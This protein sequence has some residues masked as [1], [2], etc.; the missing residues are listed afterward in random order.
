MLEVLD[1]APGN[2]TVWGEGMLVSARDATTIN[3]FMAHSTYLEDGSRSTGGHPSSAVIPALLALGEARSVSGDKVILGL[4]L[5]YEIFI[6]VGK[7]L[8]PSTVTRGFQPTA[9]LAS[10]G[11]AGGCA[12]LLDLKSDACAQALAIGTNLG[13]GL[14]AALHEAASQPLQVGRSCEGG[15]V[16]ALLAERGLKGYVMILESYLD[17]HAEAPDKDKILEDLGEAYAIEETYLKLHGGC[18]GNHAP[19]D[20]SLKIIQEHDLSAQEIEKIRIGID[21]VTAGAEIHWP[22]NGQEAQFS[23]PFSVAAALIYGDASLFQYTGEKVQDPAVRGL[24]ERVQV[25]IEP[26]LD[27]LLPSK[28]GAT[29]EVVSVDGRSY[30]DSLEFAR[31][32]PEFPLTAQE[33]EAKFHLLAGEVLGERTSQVID[34]IYDLENLKTINQLTALL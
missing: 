32:E 31:G 27:K 25:E 13:S 3:S 6:R 15:L 11:P 9:I 12:K 8:Y 26:A 14:K 23:I 28:R 20:L 7:A 24:M 2:S 22:R 18:R 5:G 17:A 4:V 19:V 10:L 21:S 16:A 29:G 33:I 30:K 34:T 1:V